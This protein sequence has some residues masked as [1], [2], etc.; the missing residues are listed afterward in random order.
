VEPI[1]TNFA[2]LTAQY[3]GLDNVQL[4]RAAV[5]HADGTVSM[6]KAREDGRWS[7]NQW[8]G[9]VASFSRQH[10]LTH[11]LDHSEIVE[12]QVPALTLQSIAEKY[13]IDRIGFLQIDTEGFDAEVVKMSL[14]LNESPSFINFEHKHLPIDDAISVLHQVTAQGYIWIQSEYDTLAIKGNIAEKWTSD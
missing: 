5:S 10:L 2:R 7:G 3:E 1:A 12:E 13:Q 4:L 14:K 11:G 6:Y 9:Q 8:V